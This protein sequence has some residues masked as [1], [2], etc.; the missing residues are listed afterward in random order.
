[1][2]TEINKFI[3]QVSESKV[4][5]VLRHIEFSQVEEFVGMLLENN[6]STLEITLNSPDAYKSIE[7]V[8]KKFPSANLGAGTVVDKKAILK[9][10]DI[11][12]KFIVSPN[13]DPEV[14]EESLKNN[15]LPIPGFYTATEGF[16]AIK[17]GA[18][19]LKL[20]PSGGNGANLLK[21]YSAVF[22]DYINFIPTGGGNSK[23]I[24]NLLN[25][26]IAVGI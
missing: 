1:M 12:T 8:S 4:V 2:N 19:I 25:H 15:L 18:R 10:V 9:L 26:S 21:D 7:L 20:F 23:N 22:P 6:L 5:V 17:Y 16:N 3:E 13:T 24:L 11:G 14:I